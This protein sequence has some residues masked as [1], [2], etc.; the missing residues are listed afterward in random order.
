MTETT[1]DETD[2]PVSS[3]KHNPKLRRALGAR[4]A[5]AVV[6][7]NVIGSGIFLKPGNIAAESGNFGLI[8]TV[9][10]FGGVLCILGALC[11]AELAAMLPK[12]GGLYV[13]I[14]EAYGRPVAFLSGWNEFLFAKPASIGALSIAFTGS[15]GLSMGW[16]LSGFQQAMCATVVV[17]VLCWVNIMGVIWGGRLQ[18]AV[19]VVKAVF[20]GLVAALPFILIP[21]VDQ[22]IDFSNY[23]TTVEPRQSSLSAQIGVV[24]LAV[25]WAYNGWNG[26][27]PL[28]EEVRAPQ[29][30]LPIS[31]FAGIGILIVLY[32]SA[33]FAYHG[34]LSMEEMAGA[35]DHAAELMLH[36]LVGPL[37]MAAMSAVIMC[38]TF[39]A[40]NTN[41]LIAPR[42]TYAMGRDRVFF[43]V[44]SRVHPVYRTPVPAILATALMAV[45]LIFLVPIGQHLVRDVAVENIN[46]P[47]LQLMVGSLQDSSIFEL[48]TNFIIF[49]LSIFVTL[50]VLAV[51]V[52]RFKR[53]GLE[54]PYK[55]WGF[56]VTPIIFL[57]VYCWFMIQIY[58]N[59]PLESRIGLLL[60][61][62]GI[63]FYYAYRKWASS[64]PRSFIK[65][66]P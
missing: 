9:W 52:L 8:I 21:W 40:I 6:V 7:G 15:L 65:T 38:S 37:G 29:R 34:V 5:I 48:L 39:G 35:G 58:L 36:K 50:A 46:S 10:I 11:L 54:R 30:N 53:P 62:L 44:F 61:A 4:I 12:A 20:L 14:R 60:I 41:I 19:T 27:V 43:G 33:N 57:T 13:Y 42:V 56:P 66:Y 49:S 2:A 16:H 28:A 17:G 23:G 59:K 31:L 32:L 22:S 25:M 55:T 26:I 47:V 64:K 51:I 18:L 24:L 3:D 45:L 63:P 1:D